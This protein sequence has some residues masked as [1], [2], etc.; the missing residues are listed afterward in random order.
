VKTEFRLTDAFVFV[1]PRLTMD[2]NSKTLE[3]IKESHLEALVDSSVRESYC[4]EFKKDFPPGPDAAEEVAKDVTAMANWV[5]GDIVYG[6]AEVDGGAASKVFGLGEIQ[7]SQRV[8]DKWQATIDAKVVPRIPGLRFQVVELNGGKYALVIRVPKSYLAPHAVRINPSKGQLSF[9][10][11]TESHVRP[12]PEDEV[13]RRYV[14]GPDLASRIDRLRFAHVLSGNS[15]IAGP[16]VS[17]AVRVQCLFVPLVGILNEHNHAYPE[18]K[19]AINHLVFDSNYSAPVPCLEGALRCAEG[20]GGIAQSWCIFRN[21]TVVWT[22]SKTNNVRPV[23]SLKL[24]EK[25]VTPRY[26]KV[27]TDKFDEVKQAFRALGSTGQIAVCLSLT[28]A[29]GAEIM[30]DPYSGVK[31]SKCPHDEIHAPPILVDSHELLSPEQLK[32]SF[33]LVMNA[34]GFSQ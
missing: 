29:R 6:I 31:S 12:M 15:T 9:W 7:E 8:V 11:R 16:Y 19:D 26:V 27:L 14:S 20:E 24:P 32:P 10:V 22:D 18:L 4:L 1:Y 3:E 5:G 23:P 17:G 28:N 30:A 33:D 25:I 13:R 21:G 2:L 34:F